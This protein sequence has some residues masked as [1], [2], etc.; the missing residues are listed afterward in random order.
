MKIEKKVSEVLDKFNIEKEVEELI[1][2]LVK[3][4]DNLEINNVALHDE[5]IELK[6][7]IEFFKIN[8]DL[9]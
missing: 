8:Y 4:I 9:K 5:L 6:D 2:E 3:R 7:K 1:I